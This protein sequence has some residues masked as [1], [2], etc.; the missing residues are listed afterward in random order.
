MRT[1]LRCTAI[2]LLI[3]VNSFAQEPQS[4]RRLQQPGPYGVYGGGPPAKPSTNNYQLE[5][6]VQ[7]GE[8]S[9]R[10]ML[11][12]KRR[13][14]EHRVDGPPRREVGQCGAADHEL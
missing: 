10:Y 12:F 13:Y 11:T 3:A 2:I 6:I 1:I 9:A 4:I 5:L 8:S 7:R 14:R